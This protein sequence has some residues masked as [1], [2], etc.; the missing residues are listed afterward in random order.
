MESMDRIQGRDSAVTSVL[1]RFLPPAAWSLLIFVTIPWGRDIV[2]GLRDLINAGFHTDKGYQ[3]VGDLAA[4]G[5]IAVLIRAGW[6]LFQLRR[7][8][9]ASRFAGLAA[10]SCIYL[11]FLSTMTVSTEKIHF[12]EYGYLAF[13]LFRAW[14]PVLSTR[15]IWA[16]SFFSGLL[17][18]T[19]DETIQHYHPDRS[20]EF[21]DVL[22]NGLAVLLPLGMISLFAEG[23]L[24]GLLPG[25]RRILRMTAVAGVAA[26]GAF[27]ITTQDF[28]IVIEKPGEYRF[29]TRFKSPEEL[30]IADADFSPA[31]IENLSPLD[32]GLFLKIHDERT[33]PHLNE[34]RVHLFRRD[35]YIGQCVH[36]SVRRSF[37][38][39]GTEENIPDDP[40]ADRQGRI[41]AAHYMNEWLLE[42]FGEGYQSKEDFREQYHAWIEGAVADWSDR[43]WKEYME[44]HSRKAA[45]G[46]VPSEQELEESLHTAWRENM[47][48]ETHFSGLLDSSKSRWTPPFALSIANSIRPRYYESAVANR[49]LWQVDRTDV[50]IITVSIIVLFL[51]A[52]GILVRPAQLLMLSAA[53]SGYLIFIHGA[54]CH[55]P[56]ATNAMPGAPKSASISLALSAPP[57]IDGTISGAEWPGPSLV[58]VENSTGQ[59]A[60]SNSTARLSLS[61]DYLHVGFELFD[62]TPAEAANARDGDLWRYDAVE[63]FIDTESLGRRYVE[64]QVDRRSAFYDALIDFSDSIDFDAAKKWNL[65]RTAA[66]TSVGRDTWAAEIRIPLAGLGIGRE[67]LAR[68][69]RLNL[70]R[71]DADPGSPG[72]YS[73]YAW[74]PTYRWFHAP[75][76]FGRVHVAENADL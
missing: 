29:F 66:A 58:M 75:D 2:Y 55:P 14:E 25:E 45:A 62:S 11:Y 73:Y 1:K 44:K 5:V 8:L 56:F 50:V 22:W 13:L 18:G 23:R 10:I 12:L 36:D 3:Y 40:E 32:Y 72:S 27:S 48:L 71:V 63:V 31:S 30:S 59:Y 53:F 24:T 51:L 19:I 16:V 60:S 33:E 76:R 67:A 47:I 15:A 38:T 65:P 39:G 7:E 35:R 49:I 70:Y 43:M 61:E 69:I 41:Y 9:G 26:I 42:Q 21:D 64:I 6:R 4:L 20:G 74:S 52:P 37:Q 68:G 54:V 28:G 46:D 34:F 57:L 17:V